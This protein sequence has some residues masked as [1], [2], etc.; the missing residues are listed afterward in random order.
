MAGSK[1]TCMHL[2][3][4]CNVELIRAISTYCNIFN[5]QVDRPIIVLVIVY[6]DIQL[7]TQLHR[8]TDMSVYSL[9]LTL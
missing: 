1:G 6:T 5:F 7:H 8:Q 4:V 3:T 9:R 2:S